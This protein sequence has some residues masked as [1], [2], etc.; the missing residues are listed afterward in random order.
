M[1]ILDQG[2]RHP[3]HSSPAR[4]GTVTMDKNARIKH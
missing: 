2:V 1:I 3:P 4:S